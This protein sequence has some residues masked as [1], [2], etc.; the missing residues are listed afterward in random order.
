MRSALQVASCLAVLVLL[1]GC[2]GMQGT[3]TTGAAANTTSA[4]TTTDTP[5][6]PTS[7]AATTTEASTPATT[8]AEQSKESALDGAPPGVRVTDIADP[9]ALA[10][11]NDEALAGA[12]YTRQR[13]ATLTASNGTELVDETA[14]SRY[15]AN[16]TNVLVER[17]FAGTTTLAG[18]D[19]TDVTQ[20]YNGTAT[21]LRLEGVDG[22]TYVTIGATPEDSTS[23]GQEL[24]R[25]YVDPG[26]VT[27]TET[28]SGVEVRL[29]PPSGEETVAGYVVDAT[30]R[31]VTVSVTEDGLVEGFRVEYTGTL[32]DDPDVIVRGVRAVEVTA[33]GETTVERPAWVGTGGN[34]TATR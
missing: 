12:N 16:H 15:A 6:P 28:K 21:T 5:T 13:T 11:A 8:T 25:Y 4:E 20:W 19:V 1:A 34:A 23:L 9:F 3:D 33:V 2:G 10:D 22:T 29:T 26:T 17:S 31:T 24:S 30:N 14:T 32:V 18:V 27:T 7:D